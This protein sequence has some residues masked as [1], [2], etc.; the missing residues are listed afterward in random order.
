MLYGCIMW[1]S[2]ACHYDTLRRA[3]HSFL[4]RFNG[5]RKKNRA[6]H[7][8]SYLDMLM[9]TGS[10]R[11]EATLRWRRILL[12][13]FVACME[14]TR[15]PK[16]VMFGEMV[17]GAGCMGG[18]RKKSERGVLWTTSELSVSTPTSGPLQPKT[19]REWRRTAEQGAGRFMAKYMAAEKDRARRGHA[20]V[21]SNVTGR[22]KDIIVKSKRAR[23]GSL[24]FWRCCFFRVFLYHFRF[25]FVWRVRRTFSPSGWCFSTL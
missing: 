21:C 16:C 18:G 5:W 23:A 12:V 6:D 9:K 24:A 19:K 2:C 13:I 14:G 17:G 8:I 10:G 7:S 1:S 15:L 4:T 22:T 11:I 25:L 3:Y 20:V